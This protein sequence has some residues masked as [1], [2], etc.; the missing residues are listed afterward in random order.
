MPRPD[1]SDNA[2]SDDG[3]NGLFTPTSQKQ[4][5]PHVEGPENDKELAQIGT[6]DVQNRQRQ[7]NDV[8]IF[9]ESTLP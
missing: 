4:E 9:T 1:I 3:G 7:R 2:S 5:A 8:V 6:R